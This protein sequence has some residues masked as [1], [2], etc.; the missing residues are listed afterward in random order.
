[1]NQRD[2]EIARNLRQRL[3]EKVSVVEM[4]VFGS[5]ARGDNQSDS[6]L[7]VFVE[8][9]NLDRLIRRVIQ[10]TAWELGLDYSVLIAPVV[11]SRFEVEQ[12]PARSSPLMEAVREEG[13]S[14]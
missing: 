8:V 11:F 3:N 4:K 6:D 12:S 14:V 9:E 13:I 1:M 5:R 7:D 10:D 2:Y